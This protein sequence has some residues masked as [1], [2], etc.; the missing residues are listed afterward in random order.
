MTAYLLINHLL[1]FV[2]PAAALAVLLLLWSR[3]SGRLSRKTPRKPLVQRWWTQLVIVFGAGLA[4]LLLGLLVFGRDGKMMAYAALVLA[5][6]TAHWA[7]W[8]GWKA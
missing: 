2:A 6:A 7:V 8:R 1:N 3:L 4:A 5:S